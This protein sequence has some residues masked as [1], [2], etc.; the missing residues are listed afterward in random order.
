MREVLTNACKAKAIIWA[1]ENCPGDSMPKMAKKV[2]KEFDSEIPVLSVRTW[3][4]WYKSKAGEILALAAAE[5]TSGSLKKSRTT[6]YG[7]EINLLQLS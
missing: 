4:R 1:R 3:A 6:Q 2:Q 5:E 7:P